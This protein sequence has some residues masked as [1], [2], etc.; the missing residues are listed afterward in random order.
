MKSTDRFLIVIVAGVVLVVGVTI[1]VVL[2]RSGEAAYQPDDTAEG[3]AHNYL[4]ALQWEDYARA[5]SYLSPDLP[6]YP[7]SV[8]EFTDDVEGNTW[9]FAGYGDNVSLAVE[10]VDVNGDQ[11]EVSVRRTRF[12]SG[13]VFDSGHSSITFEMT[14]RREEGAW[15]VAE[16]ERY[17]YGCWSKPSG[18]NCP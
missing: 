15:R 1:A 9:S 18:R 14:L 6:G 10:A 12:Y 17:W 16:S 8:Q 4:L 3:V 13:G 11:A 7:S 5:H 2:L